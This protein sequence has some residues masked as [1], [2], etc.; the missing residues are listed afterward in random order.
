MLERRRCVSRERAPLSRRDS[1]AAAATATARTTRVDASA[2]ARASERKARKVVLVEAMNHD[3]R[4]LGQTKNSPPP[5]RCGGARSASACSLPLARSW[6]TSATAATAAAAAAAAT[7]DANDRQ[8][9]AHA[10]AQGSDARVG[11][12]VYLNSSQRRRLIWQFALRVYK[13]IAAYFWLSD[14]KL[15]LALF[16]QQQRWRAK[17][18][19]TRRSAQARVA[20]FSSPSSTRAGRGRKLAG[21]IY[22]NTRPAAVNTAK[23]A[24]AALAAVTAASAAAAALAPTLG[25]ARRTQSTQ[26]PVSKRTA[27]KYR[28]N[29]KL[30]VGT[31]PFY[32][33]SNAC[34][35]TTTA[36]TATAVATKICDFNIFALLGVNLVRFGPDV[37]DHQV[38]PGLLTAGQTIDLHLFFPYYGG[39]YNYTTVC[40]PRVR[41]VSSVYTRAA[42][43]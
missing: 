42:E 15:K 32:G 38:H 5:L 14:C 19:R 28:R 8:K 20:R 10:R 34:F 21:E 24:A 30:F 6:K 23:A 11:R 2:R 18:C 39:L 1:K 36:A 43:F 40:S 41:E 4:R 7:S 25:R 12:N 22:P 9:G 3:L 17:C 31:N 33:K 13:L 26:E 29:T 37:G 27:A 16:L 35:A